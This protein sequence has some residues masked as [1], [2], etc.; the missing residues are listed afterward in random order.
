LSNTDHISGDDPHAQAEVDAISLHPQGW[1]GQSGRFVTGFRARP[2]KPYVNSEPV[3]EFDGTTPTLDEV[4]RSAWETAL[5]G[6][7]WVNQNDT[8]FGW[9]RRSRMA[10]MA[11]GRDD[12]YAI[13]GH[14]ARFFNRSGVWFWTLEPRGDLASSGLCLARPGEEY[15]V[16]VPAS[17]GVAVDLS[18]TVGRWL[19]VRW[20]DP[21]TGRMSR[22]TLVPGGSLQQRFVPPFQ[23]DAVLHVRAK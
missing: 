14:C 10:E 18:D 15:V 3:P 20:F 19:A 1:A 7:S 12:A 16:Y 17:E 5:A 4:R 13:A 23:G 6:A 9:D 22:N 8:S 11:R 21:Q 2:A